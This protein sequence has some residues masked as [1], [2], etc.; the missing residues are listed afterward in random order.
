MISAFVTFADIYPAP[1]GFRRL[2]LNGYRFGERGSSSGIRGKEPT[3]L[4]QC[5]ANKRDQE[6]G[7]MKR[8]PVRIRT[9]VIDGY[10]MIRNADVTHYH[11]KSE[12]I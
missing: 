4:W 9:K 5:T 10:E 2:I 8:C 7:K 11:K 12:N 3:Q 1:N 6:T